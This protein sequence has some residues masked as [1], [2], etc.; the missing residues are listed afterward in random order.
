[1]STVKTASD[2]AVAADKV[3]VNVPTGRLQLAVADGPSIDGC[4]WGLSSDGRIE[5]AVR[6]PDTSLF[7]IDYS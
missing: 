4:G 7:I 2:V 6:R 5:R 3:F 1:M